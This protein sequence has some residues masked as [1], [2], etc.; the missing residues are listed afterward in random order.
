MGRKIVSDAGPILHLWEIGLLEILS[1]TGEVFIPQAVSV[2]LIEINSSWSKNIPPWVRIE[3]LS[4]QEVSQAGILCRAGLLDLGEAEAIILAKYLKAN[5]F[6]T[7]DLTARVFANSIGLECHCSLGI[8]L[9]SCAVGK[10][11]CQI[12]F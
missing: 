1:E 4:T 9:W 2:E 12:F 3:Q 5:W 7:D 11:G 6:L 8:I 10:I